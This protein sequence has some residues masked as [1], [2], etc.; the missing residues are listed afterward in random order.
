MGQRGFEA[1]L[2]T[3]A[4]LCVIG[5][6]SGVGR[7][8]VD[9]RAEGRTRLLVI[10]IGGFSWSSVLAAQGEAHMPHLGGILA[11]GCAYG[12]VIA[13]GYVSDTEILASFLTGRFP[14]NHGIT[15]YLIEGPIDG[16]RNPARR[17]VWDQIHRA[18]QPVAVVG[19]PI[20]YPIHGGDVLVI[21]ATR[22]FP[23][24]GMVFHDGVSV[25]DPSTGSLI[26]HADKVPDAVRKQIGAELVLPDTVQAAINVCLADDLTITAMAEQAV[27][28]VPGAHLFVCLSGL[29]MLDTVLRSLDG[30]VVSEPMRATLLGRYHVFLDDLIKRLDV[31]MNDDQK[32][33]FII[34]EGG[35]RRTATRYRPHFP[36]ENE[37]PARGFF[38][39][40]GRNIRRT[41]S[42]AIVQPADVAVTLLYL[43]E[44]PLPASMDGAVLHGILNDEFFFKHPYRMAP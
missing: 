11:G 2:V 37:W 40:T 7:R 15:D 9:P 6:I 23:G 27:R 36:S 10:D 42:P 31:A 8:L 20:W 19:F 28:T 18:G 43:V 12:D 41:E 35:N 26:V 3:V 25:R 30:A 34:S 1:T 17:L 33:T 13:Q 14:V 22:F 32:T 5:L 44:A 29:S 39:A 16:E 24:T 4:F 21:P 38:L